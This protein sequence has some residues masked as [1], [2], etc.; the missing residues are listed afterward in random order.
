MDA[1]STLQNNVG[2][3]VAILKGAAPSE[4]HFDAREGTE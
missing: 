2:T 3:Q 4:L 1:S